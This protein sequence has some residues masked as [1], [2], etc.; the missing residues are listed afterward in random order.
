MSEIVK[1]TVTTRESNPSV[2]TS[3]EKEVSSSKTVE[4]SIYF[5]FGIIEVLLAFRLI[6]K[7]V[8]ASHGSYFVDLIYTLTGIFII[9]FAGIFRQAVGT[10][11]ETSAILEPATL[12]AI[13]VYVILAW[14]IVSL[15]GI[16]SGEKQTA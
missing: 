6:F 4:R 2:K 1:E 8:G 10:G 12:V 13:V 15:V 11:V 14:G 16:L 3:G 9:P 7:L 5:I